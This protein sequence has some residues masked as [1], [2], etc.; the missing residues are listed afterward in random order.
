MIVEAIALLLK[1]LDEFA[2]PL[3]SEEMGLQCDP[4]LDVDLDASDRS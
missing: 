4:T 1:A 3:T 2:F